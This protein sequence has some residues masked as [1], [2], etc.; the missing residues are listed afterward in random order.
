MNNFIISIKRFFQNKNTVTI[1]GVILIVGLLYFGYNSKINDA[2][3]P[4]SVPVA[5]QTI[6]PRTKITKDMI[7]YVK[8][9]KAGIKDGVVKS[10]NLVIGKYANINST[11]PKGS[12]FYSEMLVNEDQLPDSAFV[13]VDEGDVPYN[14]AVT[15]A[16]TYGNSMYPGNYI[17][18][19]MKAK[20]ETGEIMV[21]K[22]IEDVKVLAVKDSSGRNVFD[23][24]AEKRVPAYL[25]FGVSNEIHIL[26]RKATYLSG[27]SYSIELFPVPHGGTVEN[28]GETVVSTQYLKDFINAITIVIDES[29]PEVNPGE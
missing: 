22:L 2:T 4:I 25:I 5:K 3:N 23:N 20:S 17:D 12:M 11:I 8:I 24:L 7:E 27:S 6:Q 19:Y 29:K 1:I 26:L 14:F 15:M 13:E 28:N 9:P 16:S 18:I 21:G 10:S